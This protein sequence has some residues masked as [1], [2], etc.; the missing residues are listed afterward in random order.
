MLSKKLEIYTPLPYTFNVKN[1]VHKWLLEIP[2]DQDLKFA[3]FDIS[4][5]YSNIP[6]NELIKVID[7]MCDQHDIKEE[8]KHEI[9][10]ISQIL[11]KQN[12]FRFQD[13]IYTQ[14]EGLAMGAPISSIFSEIYLQHIENTNIV[15][16]LLKHHKWTFPLCWWYSPSI[17]KRH[18]KHIWRS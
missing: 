4:N 7:L 10:K 3:S 15:D 8:P 1:T 2:Y 14:E 13:T 9:M 6:T 17:Q 11:I 12:Y 5:M 16:I 18:S